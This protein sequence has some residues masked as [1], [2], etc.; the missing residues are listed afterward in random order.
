VSGRQADTDR[1]YD[2]LEALA[3]ASGGPRLLSGTTRPA[4]WPTHGVYFFFEPGEV[5]ADGRSRVVRVGTHAL[6]ATSETTL[7][8]RLSQHRGHLKG[9]NPGG[10]NHRGSIFRL[11]VGA[12]LITCGQV[13]GL[14]LS[15]W[16]SAKPL[17]EHRDAERDCE[18]AVSA[19]I[20]QMPVLWL[21]VPSRD[22][23]TSDR[24]LVEATVIALLSRAAG[25]VDPASAGWLGQHAPNQ[26]IAESGLWNVRHV[27]DHYDPRTLAVLA[28]YI[29]KTTLRP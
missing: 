5:R 15:A 17:P 28:G 18:R 9:S 2:L 25:G 6:T 27:R 4:D 21:E 11:H 22:D 16:L 1:V 20:G 26:A 8:K 3:A 14:P 24:G 19:Y 12:A 7:W 13:K 23:G 10:G 29:K